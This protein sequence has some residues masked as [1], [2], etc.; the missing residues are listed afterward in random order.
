MGSALLLHQLTC[1][2]LTILQDEGDV[3]STKELAQFFQCE[4][5]TEERKIAFS[6]PVLPEKKNREV[7]KVEAIVP[8]VKEQPVEKKTEFWDFAHL[9]K[10]VSQCLPEIKVLPTIPND[11]IAYQIAGRWKTKNQVAPVTVLS[12]GETAETQQFLEQVTKALDAYFGPAKM[13]LAENIEKENQWEALLSV[14]EL[15]MILL[16]DHALWQLKSLLPFYK[17][18]PAPSGGGKRFLGDVPL[19]LLPDLTLYLKDCALK[20]SLWHMLSEKI[21]SLTE[22]Q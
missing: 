21:R 10:I 8:V 4:K 18:N 13:I 6:L 16:C 20:K 2:L 7:E 14:K 9:H 19:F 1:D 3:F 15:K 22:L 11:A 17:E 12:F 5:K